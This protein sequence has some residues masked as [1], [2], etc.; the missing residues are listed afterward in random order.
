MNIYQEKSVVKTYNSLHKL[1]LGRVTA[2]GWLKEQLTR[3]KHGTG[4]HLDEL[5]PDMI[6]NP[7][8]NYSC[9]KRLPGRTEDA[10]P[11]FA[12]GWS[13]EISGT[14][15]T[16]LVQLAYTLDDA[17]LKA[18]ATRWIE[19]VLQHQ[20]PDGYLGSYN[21][22]T[23]NRNADYNA[24]S[25]A[26]CYRAMLS[27]YEATGRQEVLEAVHR[28]L[29]W[30]CQ[31]WKD[32]KTDYVGSIIIEAMVI[33]YTY[34]G[35]DRL[36]RFSQDWIDWLEENSRWQN[37]VSQYLSDSLP[38]ASM[39]VVA[40]GED[41]KHPGILYCATGNETYKEAS[42]NAVRK[43]L[44][45]I[46]QTTGG[47]SSCM[48]FL[49]PKGAVNETEYCNFSTWSHSYSWYAMITGQ[50][51]WGDQIERILFNGSQG[52]RKK[53]EK[54][55]AYMS[56]P[57]QLHAGEVSGHFCGQ[58]DMG[59]YTPCHSTACCPTQMVRLIPEFVRGMCMLNDAG[60]PHIFCYGPAAIQGDTFC[61]EMDTLYPFRDTITLT[62]VQA[63]NQVL[64]LRIPGWCREPSATVNGKPANLMDAGNGFATLQTRL[65]SGD[66]VKLH[67]PMELKITRVDD[68]AS[69]SKFPISIERGPLVYALPVLEKWEP[70]AGRPMTPLPEGWHWFNADAD[71]AAAVPGVHRFVAYTK[72]PWSKAID[73]RIT[74]DQITVVE[75]AVE[76][77]VWEN[78]P[79]HL[80]VPLYQ[81]PYSYNSTGRRTQESWDCPVYVEG[82]AQLCKLVP[83]GC[84]N[85]RITY[86]PRA[87]L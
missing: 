84:T 68:S 35:D 52:A 59:A 40:Y 46:V 86:I 37:K 12:A 31:N 29:L 74:T 25:A 83:H 4:G 6:A 5:E 1:P 16:G 9:F 19:G 17:E 69:N 53:D 80:Q 18:K 71:H 32:H 49:S 75:D 85:L 60:E 22:E 48:E 39:H 56:A 28:G 66:V 47:P 73:E 21:P 55:N 79:I 36:I 10:E 67:F 76:G 54:A 24:W 26:W 23:T 33:V 65:N 7:F 41:M 2:R 44:D 14:Y 64:H 62:A 72:A 50:A 51:T 63:E 38:Y 78:P 27:Y 3:S 20:E 30:F 13:G 81:A 77:Y 42:L 8:I 61:F 34:T 11:T 57:N 15:W 87:K 45:K 82:E 43:A 58:Y 70:Y